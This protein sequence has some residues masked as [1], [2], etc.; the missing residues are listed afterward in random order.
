L[1]L[2]AFGGY[3]LVLLIAGAL[4]FR[5]CPEDAKALQQVGWDAAK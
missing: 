5:T 2:I 3:L 4:S 1:F